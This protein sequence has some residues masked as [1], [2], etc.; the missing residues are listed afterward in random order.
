M[1][2]A[3]HG[4]RSVGPGA[5]ECVNRRDDEA[6]G[7]VG[8]ERLWTTAAGWPVQHGGDRIYVR[9][10]AVGQLEPGRRVHPGIDRDDENPESM[11]L[12]ATMIPEIHASGA[13]CGPTRRNRSEEDRL[14]EERES[15]ERKRNR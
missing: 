3:R 5:E 1:P 12:R 2:N 11:P 13:E 10:A 9:D 15:L 4:T 6:G 8:G 7:H 14:G